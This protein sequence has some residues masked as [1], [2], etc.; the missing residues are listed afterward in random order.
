MSIADVAQDLEF[1]VRTATHPREWIA[2]L[3][4]LRAL[5]GR[6]PAAKAG[7][8]AD[9]SYRRAL[10]RMVGAFRDCEASIPGD[11]RAELLGLVEAV[12]ARVK[13]S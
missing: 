1:R 3:L 11:W 8:R 10:A 5:E 4:R 9:G 6:L 13:A 2:V 7:V 12:A